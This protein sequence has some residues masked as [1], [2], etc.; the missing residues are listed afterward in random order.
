MTHKTFA[1][2]AA[3]VFG[4]GIVTLTGCGGSSNGGGGNNNPP[5]ISSFSTSPG[6]V[7]DGAN[8]KLTGV[9]SNGTGVITPGN[10][11]VTSGT[12]VSVTP[13][14]DVTTTYTLTVTGTS[15]ATVS[16]TTTAQAVAAPAITSFSASSSTINAGGS[17][18]LNAVFTGGTGV[19]TPGNLPII[20]G[21]PLTVSPTT[22]TTYTI[23]ITNAATTAVTGTAT[24]TVVPVPAITSF[25][26]S[27]A[28]IT[29]GS[30]SSLTAVFTGGTGVVTPGNITVTSGTAVSVK[31]T[32]TTTYTLTVSG[33]G[34]TNAVQTA[35]V[36]VVGAPVITSFSA[37]PVSITSGASSSLTAVFTGGTGVVTPGNITVT[38]GTAVSVKP[39][40]T[41]TYTLTV[42]NAAS[43]AVTQTASVTVVPAPTI[44]S[45]TATPATITAG[46]GSSLNAVFTGGTG[47]VTP[48]NIV[49]TSG[50]AVSVSPGATTTYTLTVTPTAGTAVTQQTTVTVVAAPVITSFTASPTAILA[51]S[52]SK[53]TGVFTG[54]TGLI[55][56]GN[57]TA[58]S[59][60]SISV[61]PSSTTT[62]T[63][64]VKNAAGTTVT[65]TATVTITSSTS[66]TVD[67]SS[68]TTIPVT[69]Q[70]LGMNLATWYDVDSNASAI[71]TAM[72]NAGI[73]A[74]RW[75]GGSWSDAY[76]WGYQ[77]T[78]SSLTTPYQCT[79]SS[80]TS[81]TPASSSTS[82]G[83]YATFANFE[84]DIVKGGSY[85]LALTA[86]YGT[87]E[88]CTAGGD[89]KEAAAWAAAAVT[90]GV[91]VSHMTVGNEEYGSW[92]TDLHAKPNDPATYAATVVG[93]SGY[94]KLIKAASPST[95]VGIDV[96]ADN[97]PA[98]W[99]ATVMGNA[100]GSYDFVELHYYPQGPGSENDT[101][102]TQQAAQGLTTN[103]NIL[104]KELA[105]A[106]EP[107]TP[108]YVGEMGSVYSNPGKQSW[109]ITQGLY[110]G[111]MLGEM[112]NDGVIRSTW[113]I[114]FGNCNGQAGNDSSSVYGWQ[115]FGAYN[116]FSDGSGENCNYGGPIGT[117]SPTA[118]AYNLFQYVAVNG[119]HVLTPTVSGDSTD[120]RAYAATHSGGTALVL[121]NVNETTSE[122]VTVMVTG[123]TTSSDV[124]VITY[125]KALYDQ[126][127][128]T[129]PV[130]AAPTT[131]DMG[132]QAVPLT[133]TLSP[134]SMN[135]V[136]IQ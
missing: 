24:V 27:P 6:I 60:A 105:T 10:T 111:Q 134:W 21:T 130:W 129:T 50:T 22:T 124:K 35:V 13:P 94:Y 63:L 37:S 72:G 44:T 95:V 131:T 52:T 118:E 83:G 42:T 106:G 92:E 116:V 16:A 113:W 11:S 127:D 56:P 55:T 34:G 136:L 59:G 25:L 28:T 73:K 64:T 7:T 43:T 48:G 84:N 32:S 81:C 126:T 128:A 112:M 98:G 66:V 96:D 46:G 125:D 74:I 102:L 19:V 103:I 15:G 58:T 97:A 26:A 99:D 82:W 120:V 78:S 67:P 70:L 29:V 93:S 38:S 9:F 31:P 20:S 68:P 121:F 69:D 8:A 62:Y 61:G 51:G 23:T 77:T 33:A 14:N 3:A 85:D 110:A 115:T 47:L 53:L 132:S 133:L 5:A 104:K 4:L 86:N 90:D 100:K 119:E 65:A 57:Y 107:N 109:S 117:M 101:Y 87:N 75:P 123:E 30:S 76:H 36:T 79:C 91:T 39:S 49:V 71:N 122:N 88:A 12:A 114:G 40:S 80:A 41:T 89:P 135:V 1:A 18:S 2:A 45:F 17:T 108:I 54:G